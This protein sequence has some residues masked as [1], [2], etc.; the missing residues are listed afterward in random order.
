MVFLWCPW[1]SV[2]NISH[3]PNGL[4]WPVCSLGK[5]LL[6]FFLLHFA[7]QG[8]T[9][10]L[11]QVSLDFLLLHSSPIWWKG[12][13]FLVLVLEG[14]GVFIQP[15]NFSFSGISCWS[16]DLDYRDVECF[17]L[18]M[19]W[20]HSV[21]SEIVPKYLLHFG[22]FCWL[23][24]LLHFFSESDTT[25]RLNNKPSWPFF[26]HW[27]WRPP[28]PAHSSETCQ[29]KNPRVPPNDA[30]VCDATPCVVSPCPQSPV[31]PVSGKGTHELVLQSEQV[32]KPQRFVL[33][34]FSWKALSSV[35][36][37][38]LEKKKKIHTT[39]KLRVVF[40]SGP[41]LRTITQETASHITLRNCSE[42]VREKPGIEECLLEK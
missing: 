7:L 13:L 21:V 11:V 38:Q 24:G 34:G 1:L 15:F 2:Y 3:H 42:E 32:T 6:A 37:K 12:H 16:I 22:L 14:P 20:D 29:C 5:T 23:W 30:L 39:W 27:N 28:A 18:E 33:F 41:L 8:Q 35:F 10:P 17:A 9:C 36:L 26:P 19:N 40:Y 25:E 31:P 4:L